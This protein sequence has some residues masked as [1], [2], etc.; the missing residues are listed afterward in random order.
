MCVS[1]ACACPD[2][3]ILTHLCVSYSV[4][5]SGRFVVTA[6]I[7]DECIGQSWCRRDASSAMILV[8]TME[9]KQALSVRIGSDRSSLTLFPFCAK[10]Y[11]ATRRFDLRLT[12]RS[13]RGQSIRSSS[14]LSTHR[15]SLLIVAMGARG[16]S[17][18]AVAWLRGRAITCARFACFAYCPRGKL[19]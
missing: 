9:R 2:F 18:Y 5:T 17:S 14:V 12:P 1:G 11:L 7:R 8:Q 13:L 3:D 10:G 15:C 6:V 4:A 19:R 16:I